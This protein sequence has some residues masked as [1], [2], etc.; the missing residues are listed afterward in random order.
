MLVAAILGAGLFWGVQRAASGSFSDADKAKVEAVVHDYI[1][2]HPEIL[3]EAMRRLQEGETGKV[4]A[5][6]RKAIT[7]PFG[8]A[9]VGNPNGDVTLVEFY[10]YNCGYCRSSLPTIAKLIERD[11]K[12][13]IVFREWPILSE[14][15]VAAAK[16]SLAAAEQGKFKVFHDTLYAAGPVS[17]QSIAAAAKAAGVD[18]TKAAA[19]TQRAEAEIAQNRTTAQQLGL[20]GTPSWVV[21]NRA[22]SS[23]LPLEELEKAIKT[24]RA[25][26]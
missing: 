22:V 25:N 1:L 24:A 3:P 7:Q 15:S 16:V 11:P 26:N 4:I 12:L 23:A 13:K 5:A 10:D 9:W 8:D 2:S 17:E 21:G 6:N 20:T 18:M 19:M 14:E